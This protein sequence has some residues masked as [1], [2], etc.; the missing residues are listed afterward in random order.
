MLTIIIPAFNEEEIIVRTLESLKKNVKIPHKI[1]VVDGCSIDNTYKVVK[2]YSQR[3][4]N[5]E[6]I[7]TKPKDKRFASSIKVGFDKVKKGEVV[8]VM[9]D[10]CDDPRTINLMHKKISDGWDAVCGSRYMRGGKKQGGPKLQDYLS[11]L[12]CFSLHYLTGMPTSDVSNAFKM[13]KK[14]V[15][16]GIQVNPLSGVEGSM[17]I[18]LQTYFFNNAKVTEVPTKWRGRTIGQSKFKLFQRAPRYMRI[19]M[20]TLE[21]SMRKQFGMNLKKYYI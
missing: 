9:A 19:Y 16:N 10:L 7:R 6:I 15:L 5:V 8:V 17:E 1:L 3:N 11:R 20:W 4:K 21:N 18:F 14:E 2:N 13:Y 12:V